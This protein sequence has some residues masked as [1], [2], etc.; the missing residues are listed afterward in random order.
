MTLTYSTPWRDAIWRAGR[1][2][3]PDDLAALLRSDEPLR[4]GERELLACLVEGEMRRA[5]NRP[6]HKSKPLDQRMSIGGEYLDRTL[7]G[8]VAASVE[9]ELCERH[10]VKRGL[11]LKWVNEARQSEEL[12]GNFRCLW[13]GMWLV[14]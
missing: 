4:A 10:K 3:E 14:T 2:H 12:R 9:A 5:A 13:W 1:Q 6:S 11:L 8:E 7:N